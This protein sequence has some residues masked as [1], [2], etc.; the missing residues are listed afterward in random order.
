MIRLL[1]IRELPGFPVFL[2]HH[3]FFMALRLVVA[4]FFVVV[5]CV[6]HG[7]A[8]PAFRSCRISMGKCTGTIEGVDGKIME[9]F[10]L[11][12]GSLADHE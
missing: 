2:A 5:A 4:R 12:T 10:P 3:V 8:L 1:R 7:P 11:I 9:R 6:W